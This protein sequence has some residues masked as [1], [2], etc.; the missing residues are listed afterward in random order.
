MSLSSA[1][2]RGSELYECGKIEQAIELYLAAA[3]GMEAVPASLC[4]KLAR[5]YDRLGNYDE[6]CR[7]AVAVV[8]A[9]DDFT[10]WHAASALMRRY[11]PAHDPANVRSVRMAL[12]GSTTNSQL[13]QLLHLAARRLGIALDLYDSPYNQYR[14]EIIDPHSPMYVFAPDFVVLAVH[15][16]ELALPSFSESPQQEVEAEL[17]RWT[18]L[19]EKVAEHSKARVV[20]YNFALPC[21]APMGHLGAKLPGSRYAMTHALNA[22]WV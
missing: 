16:G 17:R 13:A 10:S 19:W 7:W 18:K 22:R 14:Q 2:A 6:T 12:I 20:Q 15:E 21:E 5:S 8:D 1:I 4:L 11:L 3:G 9:G